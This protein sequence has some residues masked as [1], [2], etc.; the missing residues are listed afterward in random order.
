[1][2]EIAT[3]LLKHEFKP[4]FTEE[5]GWDH[6][7]GEVALS[8]RDTPFHINVIASK[9]GFRVLQT[10]ADHFALFDRKW[11]RELQLQVF[12]HSHE[13]ILIV[14]CETLKKQVWMWATTSTRG[15]GRRHREHP[16]FSGSPPDGL[17]IRLEA[18]RFSLDEEERVGLLDAVGKVK[19]AL[20]T[21]PEL[22]LFVRRPWY[23]RKSYE[24]ARARAD[25]GIDAFRRFVEFH[26]PLLPWAAKRWS[27]Y[28]R[29]L[30]A[31]DRIQ[32][33]ALGLL[34]ASARFDETRGAQFSTYA[35]H[36]LRNSAQRHGPVCGRAIQIPSYLWPRRQ[37]AV[38][39]LREFGARAD[40]ESTIRAI[41]ALAESA[42]A[43]LEC[44]LQIEGTSTV[45]SLNDAAAPAF[46]ESRM[47]VTPCSSKFDWQERIEASHI[48]SS[49][50]ARLPDRERAVIDM[51]FGLHGPSYTLQQV[52]DFFNITR[53]RVRQLELLTLKE[54]RRKLSRS[55]GVDSPSQWK[56]DEVTTRADSA[57]QP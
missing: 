25:G 26:L 23:A 9:R 56:F 37:K 47:L 45:A 22:D 43:L 11:L 36:L 12:A 8:V 44:W 31:E 5:L 17:L 55:Y 19:S 38:K 16:F 48:I 3:Y 34:V 46:H 57:E 53:E 33:V 28:M 13:H 20:D 2:T 30:D 35:Y 4:L 15:K 27:I 14:S 51:R 7:S 50:L 39:A 42:P 40:P 21:T 29:G 10:R 1:M 6:D 24:L 32:I 52:A 18:L 41:N 49:A 54:L